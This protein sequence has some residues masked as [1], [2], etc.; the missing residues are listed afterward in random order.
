M[1]TPHPTRQEPA[2]VTGCDLADARLSKVSAPLPQKE[3]VGGQYTHTDLQRRDKSSLLL[4]PVTKLHHLV[5]EKRDRST[6]DVRGLALPSHY[7]QP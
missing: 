4:N 3:P 2:T 5:Q 1:S 7:P 6:H